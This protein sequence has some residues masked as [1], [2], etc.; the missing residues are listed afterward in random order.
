MPLGTTGV[1]PSISLSL[2][3]ETSK[4]MCCSSLLRPT[5]DFGPLMKTLCCARFE[6]RQRPASRWPVERSDRLYP[7]STSPPGFVKAD[8]DLVGPNIRGKK[9]PSGCLIITRQ[10]MMMPRLA[11]TSVQ[12]PRVMKL[13][14]MSSLFRKEFSTDVVLSI[15][16]IVTL[17]KVSLEAR[18]SWYIW[19]Q[20][21]I[22]LRGIDY[23]A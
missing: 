19:C 4:N 16:V 6:P 13:Y 15:D 22:L 20:L 2:S 9:I 14:V 10:G 12:M 8:G 5:C 23:R 21:T 3:L 17:R 1:L 11:S 7:F 18:R